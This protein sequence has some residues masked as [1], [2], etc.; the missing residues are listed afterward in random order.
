MCVCVLNGSI[1]EVQERKKQNNEVFNYTGAG[2]KDFS[3]KAIVHCIIFTFDLLSLF[4]WTAEPIVAN[5]ECAAGFRYTAYSDRAIGNV[6]EFS[7]P[8]QQSPECGS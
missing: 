1:R 7:N 5:F 6:P 3:F 4:G 8:I 2:L